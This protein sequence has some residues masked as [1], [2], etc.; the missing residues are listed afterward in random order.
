MCE[1][2]DEATAVY[3]QP[4]ESF[5]ALEQTVIS[6]ILGSC[7]SVTFWSESLRVGAMSHSQ[8]PKC[9]KTP[10][11][12][13]LASGRRYVDFAIR[14][15][16]RRFDELGVERSLIQVKLFGGA[17]VLQT[18]SSSS[19]RATVGSLNCDEAL[20]VLQDRSEGRDQTAGTRQPSV[21][22]GLARVAHRQPVRDDDEVGRFVRRV[23]EGIVRNVR[24]RRFDVS[25]RVF[26]HERYLVRA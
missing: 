8:L 2:T 7:V 1:A 11:V 16:A 20:A 26:G 19:A 4:G 24:L 13:G 22:T 18:K 25:R 12:V 15:L 9:P 6:T 5:F 17:D 23:V 3:L 14:D 10:R 21:V